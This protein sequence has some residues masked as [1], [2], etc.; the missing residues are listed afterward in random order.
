MQQVSQGSQY[1]VYRIE[2]AQRTSSSRY[3]LFSTNSKGQAEVANWLKKIQ[4]LS[5]RSLYRRRLKI[6][7]LV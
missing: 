5:I 7:P 6:W 3:F 2:Q 1:D 4:L